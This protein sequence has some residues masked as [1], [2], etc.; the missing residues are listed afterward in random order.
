MRGHQAIIAQRLKGQAPKIV[1]VNDYP[2]RT[3]WFETHDHAT[4]CTAGDALSSLDF[5]FLVGLTASISAATPQ[6][7]Q[8]LFALAKASGA[9]TVAACCPPDYRAAQPAGEWVEIFHKN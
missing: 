1:F 3:D 7:A 4:V 8:A 2:C 9:A 5:R 6:R